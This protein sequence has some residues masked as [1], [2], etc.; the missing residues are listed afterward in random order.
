MPGISRKFFDAKPGKIVSS[1][2]K[3]YR[4]SH[5]ITVNSVLAVDLETNETERLHVESL[6]DIG[7]EIDQSTLARVN[8]DIALFSDEEWAE[9]QRRLE[10]IKP[11]L[12]DPIRSRSA[13]EAIA[14]KAGTHRNTIYRWLRLFQESQHVSSLIPLRKGGKLGYSKL[15]A[16]QESIISSAIE[17]VYLNKHRRRPQSV[18]D[19]VLRRCFVAKVVAPNPISIRLRIKRLNP[20]DVL[21][22]RGQKDVAR[23][24]YEL[25]RGSFPG[26]ER[27]LD[28]VQIDHTPADVM[29][30]D[31]VHRLPIGRPFITAAIDVCSRMFVGIYISFDPP[32]ATSVALC[33]ANAIC[34]KREYLAGLGVPGDWP[35]WGAMRKIHVD[36]AREFRSAALSRGCSDNG[37]DLEYR[38]AKTPHMGGHIERLLGT[39]NGQSHNIPG[40]TFSSA[41]K[42]KGYDSERES[43]MTLKEFEQHLVDFIVNIYHRDKHDDLGMPPRKKWE[44]GIMGDGQQ[45]GIGLMPVPTDPLRVL[46][47]FLPYEM[48][49][50]QR[51][52]IRIDNIYYFDQALAPYVSAADIDD[53][54]RKRQFLVRR[55][56]RDISK[57]YF[58]D[59]ADGQYVPLPYANIG[60]P[61]MSQ[62]ELRCIQAKLREEG[63]PL[64]EHLIFEARTRQVE[65]IESAVLTSKAA[66]RKAARMIREEAKPKVPVKRPVPPEP[67]SAPSSADSAIGVTARAP[68]RVD[69]SDPFEAD[70]QPFDEIL[71]YR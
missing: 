9:G 11:L 48:R 58:L 54:K 55:D 25:L 33:L 3:R 50:V 29:I 70:I 18:V 40:T 46:L 34:P 37:I 59:P 2:S 66:R 56:P 32:S 26:A 43:V 60:Y 20:R 53:P 8:R 12:E 24:R 14:A 68:R 27:P 28:V 62:Y 69:P 45:A 71:A 5:L 65:R 21:R 63:R 30:V 38:P 19:E 16:E 31:P 35:V 61:A 67:E 10:A 57:V 23:Q 39:S 13:V 6:T 42:R 1:G 4:I 7:E 36:N 51:Y 52:G 64:D 49:S 15:S 47:D 17:D 44:L 41:Q 22:A